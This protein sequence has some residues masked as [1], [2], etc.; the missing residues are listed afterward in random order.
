MQTK[1]LVMMLMFLGNIFPSTVLA[2]SDWYIINPTENKC[3]KSPSTPNQ[4]SE[5]DGVKIEKHGFGSIEGTGYKVTVKGN[6]HYIVTPIT[7]CREVLDGFKNSKNNWS[8]IDFG[9]G[10]CVDAPF[11]LGQAKGIAGVKVTKINNFPKIGGDMYEIV[12]DGSTNYMF[13][14]TDSCSKFLKDY[15]NSQ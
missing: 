8:M 11:T 5:M 9:S 2:N 3:L 14:S 7:A 6:E 15:R 1:I 4:I 13:S 12:A 10:S